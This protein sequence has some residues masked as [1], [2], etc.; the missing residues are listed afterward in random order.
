MS[1]KNGRFEKGNQAGL[2]HGG[3]GAESRLADGRPF[4]GLAAQEEQKVISDLETQGQAWLIRE[5]AVRLT[6]AARLYWNAVQSATDAGDLAKLTTYVSKFGWLAQAALRAW[7]EVRAEG[8]GKGAVSV[9]D[10][11]EGRAANADNS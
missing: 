3:A 11:I 5:Q 4:I 9:G 8:D 2:R 1:S 10:I 7:R 6:T